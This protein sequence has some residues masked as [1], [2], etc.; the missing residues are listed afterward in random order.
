M[1]YKSQFFKILLL[2]QPQLFLA[3][4]SVEG[5]NIL[6]LFGGGNLSHKLSIWPFVT[7]LAEKGHNVTFISSSEKRLAEHPGVLD[8]TPKPFKA[9]TDGMY[10]VD[11]LQERISTG[12]NPLDISSGFYDELSLVFC[13]I[14]FEAAKTD[15]DFSNI[16]GNGKFELVFLNVAFNE[17]GF[18]IAHHFGAKYIEFSST[19]PMPWFHGV[20][21]IPMEVSWIPDLMARSSP[22]M[23][24][25]GRMYNTYRYIQGY[26]RREAFGE[27]MKGLYRDFFG[28]SAVPEASFEEMERN[29]S[30]VFLNSHHSIDFARSL[31]PMFISI[32]GMQCWS[33]VG[34]LPQV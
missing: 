24:I 14:M 5:A 17:C 23:G 4:S 6:F 2:S 28:D 25:I 11:R 7:A 19:V 34:E 33:P 9:Y 3:P 30:L 10:K 21:G 27:R 13:K 20:Y 29:S 12:G 8:L 15:P 22:P 16:V 31:P 18:F 32:G 1:K 26:S